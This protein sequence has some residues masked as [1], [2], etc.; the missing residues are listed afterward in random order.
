MHLLNAEGRFPPQPHKTLALPT[1]LVW[2]SGTYPWLSK[3]CHLWEMAVLLIEDDDRMKQTANKTELHWISI[4]YLVISAPLF[5]IITQVFLCRLVYKVL[6]TIYKTAFLF[7]FPV[8]IF[9]L[10][11]KQLQ[12][13]PSHTENVT[14]K[15]CRKT[16]T[17]A[18]N[19]SSFLIQNWQWLGNQP[20]I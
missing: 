17:K 10:D 7:A 3:C 4:T 11:N 13:F 8:F 16:F 19:S 1:L 15:D 2:E 5:A 14:Y 20:K 9:S 18:K 6:C 12:I